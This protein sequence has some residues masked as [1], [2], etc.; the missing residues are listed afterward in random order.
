MNTSDEYVLKT[1]WRRHTSLS[2]EGIFIIKT[3]AFTLVIRLQRT[4]S[5]RL[6]DEYICIRLQDVLKTFWRCFEDVLKISSRRLEDVFK[7]SSRRLGKMFS[8]HLQ[9]VFKT[10]HHFKL[11]LLTRLQDIF[12]TYSP[13][14]WD[15]LRK[16]FSTERFAWVTPRTNL[17]SGYKIFKNE[18]FGYTETFKT[19]F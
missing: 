17:W 10:Y 6:Q 8:R 18:R 9:D 19:V 5:R 11:L 2:S 16:K 3:Y 15:V 1:S 12:E 13:H 4:S 14:F 7:P